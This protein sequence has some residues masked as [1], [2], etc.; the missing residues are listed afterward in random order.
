MGEIF[1]YRTCLNG[2][3]LGFVAASPSQKKRVTAT[4]TPI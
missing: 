3:P 1:T 2:T 4:S